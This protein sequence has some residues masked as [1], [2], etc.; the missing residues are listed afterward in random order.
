MNTALTKRVVITG[1]GT[2]SPP[3]NNIRQ[4]WDSLCAAKP[5]IGPIGDRWEKTYKVFPNEAREWI[6]GQVKD[7]DPVRYFNKRELQFLDLFS[8]FALIA[9]EEAVSDAGLE[10]TDANRDNAA[11]IL[12]T[13]TGGDESRDEASYRF[14]CEKQRV[15]NFTI[16]R[17]MASAAASHVSIKLG[18]TGPTYTVQSTCA[19]ATH[20]I[21]QAF[22]LIRQGVADIAISG[23]TETLPSLGLFKGWQ[24]MR[25]LA[26][27]TCRPFSRN[28]KGLVL[29]EG[30]GILVLESLE[31]ARARGAKIYAE[32][33]GFG[34]SSDAMDIVA[35]SQRGPIA[36]MKMA[37][38]CAG[39][40]P[41]EIDYLNAHGTG[42]P[43]NDKMETSAIKSVFGKHAD[44]L[45]VSST[46]SMH[47]HALGA[48]GALESIATILAVQSDIVPPTI[49][50]T[51]KDSECDLN[52][53]TNEARSMVVNKALN[54]SFGFGG[55]NGV[56]TFSKFQ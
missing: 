7:Y 15:P 4:F 9:A 32:I 13:S 56:L 47:G 12:G 5:C 44:T 48:S 20:A 25:I 21:G 49:N 38:K 6:G 46:K 1:L 36:A 24:A 40:N 53:V 43:S 37:L 42:T 41:D 26:P 52:L 2:I 51:E 27:D 35:P 29:G 19:S 28:R 8:Q 45:A 14:F 3:G 31:H 30:A 33:T 55:L 22:W 50:F 54:N 18:I 34:M 16:V 10:I 23:G 17:T 11:V 39:Y